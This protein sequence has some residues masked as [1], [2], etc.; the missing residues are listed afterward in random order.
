MHAHIARSAIFKFSYVSFLYA[1][2]TYEKPENLHHTR[3]TV[4]HFIFYAIA[5]SRASPIWYSHRHEIKYDHATSFS[6][7]ARQQFNLSF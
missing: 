4:V 1:R 5:W 6:K 2:L 3:Y 7:V